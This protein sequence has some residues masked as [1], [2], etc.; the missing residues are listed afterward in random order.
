MSM[1]RLNLILAGLLSLTA[2]A[3]KNDAQISA[4]PVISETPSTE[5]TGNYQ[6]GSATKTTIEATDVTD[7]KG[8]ATFDTSS[9]ALVLDAEGKIVY[10]DFDTAENTVLGDSEGKLV[11]NE[12]TTKRKLADDY[13]MHKVSSIGADWYQQV[14]ALENALIGKTIEEVVALKIDEAGKAVDAD[15][16]SGC[17]IAIAGYVD[18]LKQASENMM[19]IEP[20]ADVGFGLSTSF[21]L[22]DVSDKEGSAQENTTVAAYGLDA[23]GKIVFTYFD[24]AQNSAQFNSEGHWTL[25]EKTTTKRELGNEYG[26]LKASSIG[27][28]WFEQLDA[29][30]AY[31]VGKTLDEV[32]GM[33][34]ADGLSTDVDL[35]AGCT[36]KLTP[37]ISGLEVAKLYQ[38]AL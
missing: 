4:S 16:L 33:E 9:V 26:M 14:D 24:T 7:G 2:C 38:K 1:K 6:F 27:K 17:T 5:T 11:G 3:S 18:L 23:D 28:E 31:C 34:L 25:P 32:I 29:F 22:T 19:V 8:S 21:K 13:G 15:L 20:I 10:V 12:T 35:L 36:V 37:F 30:Q